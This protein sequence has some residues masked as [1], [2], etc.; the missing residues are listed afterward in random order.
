M[1]ERCYYENVER[2]LKLAV[3]MLMKHEPPDSRAVSDEAVALAALSCG[4][5]CIAVMQVINGA[6][7]RSE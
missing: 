2:G 3:N 7:E 1:Q 5:D 4:D 6:L